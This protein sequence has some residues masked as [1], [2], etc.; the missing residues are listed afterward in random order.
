M[1]SWVLTICEQH[2]CLWMM[3]CHLSNVLLVYILYHHTINKHTI[4]GR[5]LIWEWQL[6]YL[7]TQVVGLLICGRGD[8]MGCWWL[9]QCFVH[10][11]LLQ[12]LYCYYQWEP[13]CLNS[14]GFQANP[15]LMESHHPHQKP[16]FAM[17]WPMTCSHLYHN[18][19]FLVRGSLPHY[20]YSQMSIVFVSYWI[21][22]KHVW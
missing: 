8:A 3:L 10:L 15:M 5:L 14:S 2:Q 6:V 1:M 22:I 16:T 4:I 7:C 13:L 20:Q 17:Q 11:H 9:K 19:F 18:I 12:I 21:I